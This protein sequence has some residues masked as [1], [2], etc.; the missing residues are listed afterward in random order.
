MCSKEVYQGSGE[1]RIWGSRNGAFV[2]VARW[3]TPLFVTGSQCWDSRV[4]V[5]L[6]FSPTVANMPPKQN[7]LMVMMVVNVVIK[8]N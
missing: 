3:V 2:C 1:L 4:A 7:C 6:V 8:A 5:P